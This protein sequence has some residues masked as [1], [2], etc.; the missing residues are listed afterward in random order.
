MS[1]HNPD[2][3]LCR[4][5]P[6]ITTARLC[7]N[8]DGRCPICDSYV[9]PT[10]KARICNDCASSSA[11]GDCIICGGRG[12]SDAYYC[13]ECVRLERDR[14]GC[15]RVI[16]LG[17]SRKGQHYEKVKVNGGVRTRV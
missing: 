1:A 4:H 16:N 2:L 9:R 3:V 7:E 13:A 8:D 15:P 10:V 5:Q 11:G 6:G 17:S 14:D 12:V